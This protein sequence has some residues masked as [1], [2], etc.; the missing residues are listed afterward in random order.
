MYDLPFDKPGKF[1][2][3]NLHTHST[4]SDGDQTPEEVCRIYK[5]MG[6][7]F[8]SLT[9]HFRDKYGFVIADTRPYRSEGFTTIIGAELH[10][11]QTEFGSIWHILANG[12]PFDF[13]PT[14]PHESGP[15]LAA[16][17]VAAGAFVSAAHPSWYVLTPE[18]ILSLGDVHA[19]EVFNGTSHNSNDRAWSMPI[20][21]LMLSR[22]HRYTLCATDDAHIRDHRGDVGLGWVHVRSE[23]LD[24][25]SLVTALKAG[26][27]YSSTGPEIF[28]VTVEPGQRIHVE[29]SPVDRVFLTGKGASRDNAHGSGM[30]SATFKIGPGTKFDSAPWAMV[31]IRDQYG[32]RAWTNPI[33]FD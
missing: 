3:G 11:G 12:L 20:A 33:W 2:K 19:I 9:D 29:C 10:T 17:A 16:R 28:N 7:D 15:E 26:H 31:T 27:Y 30:R 14:G 21:H 4:E 22:G 25:G 24:P 23:S 8:L 6:Y 13:A 5:S 18:D 32:R 1:W